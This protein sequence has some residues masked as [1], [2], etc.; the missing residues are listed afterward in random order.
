MLAMETKMDMLHREI[1][2]C[3]TEMEIWY[4]ELFRHLEETP[5]ALATGDK[6]IS[7]A[8]LKNYLEALRSQVEA[9]R[10]THRSK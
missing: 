9:Y 3:L 2:M 1:H 7:E 8:D 10:R 4:P 5:D 6:K